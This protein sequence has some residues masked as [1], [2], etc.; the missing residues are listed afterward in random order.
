MRRSNFIRAAILRS[1]TPSRPLSSVKPRQNKYR[2]IPTVVDEIRFDSEAEAHRYTEL[3][4][5]LAAGEIKDL[6]LQPKFP[7]TVNGLTVCTYIG[8]FQYL[9]P[10]ADRDG[11]TRIIVE[12]VKGVETKEFKIKRKL[13]LAL[14]PTLTLRLITK[15]KKRRRFYAG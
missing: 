8:D 12:D 11:P 3:K 1:D 7:F 4:L 2:N 6:K 15:Q 9:E 13:F 14:Y 5:L 10:I